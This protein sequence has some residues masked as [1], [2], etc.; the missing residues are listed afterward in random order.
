MEQVTSH[1]F[2]RGMNQ[3]RSPQPGSGAIGE[4][5]MTSIQ[6][7]GPGDRAAASHGDPRRLRPTALGLLMFLLVQF[8]LG[9]VVNLYV[10]V[11]AGRAGYGPAVAALVLHGL[12]GLALIAG[13]VSLAV[14][15][16]AARVRQAAVP[17]V[18]AAVVLL[19]AAAGGL[20][21]LGTGVDG[22][23]LVMALCAAI[24]IGCYS[25]ILY[26]LPGAG[27]V[28]PPAAGR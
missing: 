6:A 21:F 3:L 13:S 8:A 9:M 22:A 2:N 1:G 23:S 4:A 24:A 11:P 28:T 17:A 26:W 27:P 16:V 18:T 20:R 19:V 25:L 15:A 12:V 14:R 5:G 10:R 7:N